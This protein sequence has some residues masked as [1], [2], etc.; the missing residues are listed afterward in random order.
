[1]NFRLRL[2][3]MVFL[4]G[5]SGALAGAAEP[6][7]DIVFTGAP[8]SPIS[9]GV[10][11]PDG[12]AQFWSGGTVPSAIN[13]AG[14]TA[15]ERYGDTYAQGVSC[16]R[17]VAMVLEQQGLSL[18]DVVYLR[19]YVVPDPAT[20]G[21][22]D[23]AGWFKAYGEFFNCAANPVKPAR[24]TVGVAALV[25]ADWLIEVEAVAVYPATR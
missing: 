10:A 9:S 22:P 2:L 3:P 1:M 23:F 16:L 13:P 20:G 12:R 24:S 15:R 6:P 21:R 7:V 11:V 14:T 18:K 19:V 8:T 17:N 4:T 25:N 5:A